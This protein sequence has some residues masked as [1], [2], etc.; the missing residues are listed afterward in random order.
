MPDTTPTSPQRTGPLSLFQGLA[1]TTRAT[2]VADVIAGATLAAVAIP[3]SMGYTKIAGMPVITGIYTLALPVIVFALVG[4]SRHLVVGADSAT[5]AIMFA[6]LISLAKPASPEYVGLA[7]LIALLAAGYLL[8][9]RVLRLGFLA[10]FLSRTALVG[11]LSGVG[12]Q[13]ALTQLPG[14]LGV[15]ASGSVVSQMGTVLGSLGHI[16]IPAAALAVLAVA[17]ILLVERVSKRIPATLLVVAASIILAATL[18]LDRHGVAIVGSVPAGLPPIGLPHV[19]WGEVPGLAAVAA[20]IFVVVLAQSAATARSF[21]QKREEELN[22]NRDLVGLAIANLAAGVTG[23]FCVNGSPT[24]TAVVDSAG[25][26]TQLAQLVMA[27]IAIVVLVAA[28]ALLHFLPDATLAAVVFVIGIHL[29]DVAHLRELWRLRRDELAL[30]VATALVVVLVGVEQGIALAVALSV[31]DFVRRAY[32]PRDT[33]MVPVAGSASD[34]VPEPAHPGVETLP[35][36]IAYRFDG[37]LFFANADRFRQ[38]VLALV[39]A[40]PDPVSWV[41]LDLSP[42]ADIDYSAGQVLLTL[43]RDLRARSVSVHLAHAEDIHDLL[44][45]YGVL[46]LVGANHVHHGVRDA[47]AAAV[48]PDTA[49]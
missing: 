7:G 35:G 5:A 47:V 6:A 28:T 39:A 10:D 25:G 48:A 3:E 16:V 30:A 18:R 26:R 32:R 36:G 11:F 38:R 40:A 34:L 14:M 21:A 27:V 9:A 15:H 44:Q 49:G 8:I 22:E 46:D 13:V 33:V 1:G 45:R 19:S 24:K 4:S 17:V 2:V 12:V 20:S 23:A 43:L 37:T 41:V 42:V 29:V 31:L